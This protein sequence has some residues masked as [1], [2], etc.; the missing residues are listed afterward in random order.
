MALVNSQQVAVTRSLCFEAKMKCFYRRL[1]GERDTVR[2]WDEEKPTT[3]YKIDE[4][5]GF[6]VEHREICPVSYNNL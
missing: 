3:I 5:L 2:V 1:V 6:T 4:Q